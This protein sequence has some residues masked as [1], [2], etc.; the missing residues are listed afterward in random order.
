LWWHNKVLLFDQLIYFMKYIHSLKQRRNRT[1]VAS[2]WIGVHPRPN[3]G[4]IGVHS[5]NPTSV[6]DAAAAVLAL[7]SAK[8]SITSFGTL[9]FALGQPLPFS[10]A[11]D[12]K[13]F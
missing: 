12:R 3:N 11:A 9:S 10:N 2:D 13:R 4:V 8:P 7:M 1:F 6:T 5:G